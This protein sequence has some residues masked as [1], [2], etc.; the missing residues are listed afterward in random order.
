MRVTGRSNPLW[1]AAY[2]APH[3]AGTASNGVMYSAFFVPWMKMKPL[4]D[5][6]SWTDSGCICSAAQ[7]FLNYLCIN[8][9]IPDNAPLL[10]LKWI[11]EHGCQRA[12]LGSWIVAMRFRAWHQFHLWQVTA[13]GTHLLLLGVDLFIVMVQGQWTSDSFLLYWCHCEGILLLFIG[14]AMHSD[15]SILSMMCM[16]KK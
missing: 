9:D 7:A 12:T 4:G 11:R 3:K 1:H 16:F 10:P 2:N 6:I 5:C 14:S 13:S 15:S 8:S